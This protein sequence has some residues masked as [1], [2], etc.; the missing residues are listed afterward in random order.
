MLS[1]PISCGF[2]N[3]WILLLIHVH[4]NRLL[5][6]LLIVNNAAWLTCKSFLIFKF[7]SGCIRI[8]SIKKLLFVFWNIRLNL[9]VIF[10]MNLGVYKL[11]ITSLISLYRSWIL[12]NILTF[13]NLIDNAVSLVP[14]ISH[15]IIILLQILIIFILNLILYLFTNN[16]TY[17]II[18]YLVNLI[19]YLLIHLI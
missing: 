13:F 12:L 16:S 6:I 8:L 7:L 19:I 4:I 15:F 10:G 3:F 17:S 11:N 2:L 18:F 9:N 14:F 5:F 1:V